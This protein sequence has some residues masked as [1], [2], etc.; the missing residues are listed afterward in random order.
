MNDEARQQIVQTY[1]KQLRLS[2]MAR[3]C[4][5]LGSF[6]EQRGARLCGVAASLARS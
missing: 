1:L 3:D 5:S 2:C 6:A 4:E